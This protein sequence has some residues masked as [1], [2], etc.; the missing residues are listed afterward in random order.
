M[1]ANGTSNWEILDGA[2]KMFVMNMCIE[3]LR[4]M[5]SAAATT[6]FTHRIVSNEN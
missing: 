5:F 6:I 2:R 4:S 1:L 3:W